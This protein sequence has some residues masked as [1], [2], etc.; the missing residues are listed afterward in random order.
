MPCCFALPCVLV[1]VPQ[2]AKVT[3]IQL[4]D[5]QQILHRGCH[6]GVR[7][8]GQ[9]R[10]DVAHVLDPPNMPVMGESTATPMTPHPP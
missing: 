4:W 6:D 5:V 3:V 7:R 1:C 2:G 10:Y 8:R 9:V